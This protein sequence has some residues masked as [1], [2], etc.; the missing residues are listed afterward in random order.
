MRSLGFSLY[1]VRQLITPSVQ[2]V[3]HFEY[4]AF[5]FPQRNV[6]TQMSIIAQSIVQSHKRYQSRKVF[7]KINIM[8]FLLHRSVFLKKLPESSSTLIFVA[9]TLS[10][11]FGI[12]IIKNEQ[13]INSLT[14]ICILILVQTND[15]F[16]NMILLLLLCQPLPAFVLPPFVH[17]W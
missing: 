4:Y 9:S 8:S 16:S 13:T 7:G 10:I 3:R 14:L 1:L 17:E 2:I 12:L 15:I 6:S 11:F 5:T